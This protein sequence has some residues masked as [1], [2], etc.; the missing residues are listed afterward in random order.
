MPVY[1]IPV[2]KVKTVWTSNQLIE[3]CFS[4]SE[5]YKCFSV[6][7][8]SFI[9]GL[10]KRLFN[11]TQT[12][13]KQMH[14]NISALITSLSITVHCSLNFKV[15]MLQ[16]TVY[17]VLCYKV[18][19]FNRQVQRWFYHNPRWYHAR[20]RKPWPGMKLLVL[21]SSTY[22]DSHYEMFYIPWPSGISNLQNISKHVLFWNSWQL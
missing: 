2:Y 9:L 3:T 17:N 8:T 12:F 15:W 19:N 10:K 11:P 14:D 16:F 13:T 5:T 21:T 22:P 4:K 20:F 7:K 6:S 1:S 18:H